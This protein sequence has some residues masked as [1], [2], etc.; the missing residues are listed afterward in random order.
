METQAQDLFTQALEQDP[1]ERPGFLDAACAGNPALR[2]DVERL[3]ADAERAD[4][5]FADT[6]VTDGADTSGSGLT[7]REGDVI[8]PTNSASR[9]ARAVSARSGWPS[10]VCPSPAWSP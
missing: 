1:G 7:E 6:L 5:F 3:L 8:G 10:K 2:H 4:S 9:L